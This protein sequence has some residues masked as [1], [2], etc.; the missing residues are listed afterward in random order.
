MRY[1]SLFERNKFRERNSSQLLL[2]WKFRHVRNSI[3]FFDGRC[4]LSWKRPASTWGNFYV[5]LTFPP[6]L[7]SFLFSSSR[8]FPCGP[9]KLKRQK[10]FF[11]LLFFSGESSVKILFFSFLSSSVKGTI[12]FEKGEISMVTAGGSRRKGDSGKHSSF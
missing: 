12:I 1:I 6:F 7:Y 11:S 10:V 3:T 8:K 4:F 2:F 5:Y 9:G